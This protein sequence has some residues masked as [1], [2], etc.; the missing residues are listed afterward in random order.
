MIMDKHLI[1]ETCGGSIDSLGS[2]LVEWILTDNGADRLKVIHDNRSSPRG[3]EGCSFHSLA[4]HDHLIQDLPG[5]QFLDP[6]RRSA[7]LSGEAGDKTEIIA[8]ILKLACA[9]LESP[10]PS[11]RQAAALALARMGEEVLPVAGVLVTALEDG[12]EEVRFKAAF[13]LKVLGGSQYQPKADSVIVELAE[14]MEMID[15]LEPFVA[16]SPLNKGLISEGTGLT[17]EVIVD[18]TGKMFL[19]PEED[20]RGGGMGSVPLLGHRGRTGELVKVVGVFDRDIGI[21]VKSAI[22]L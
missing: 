3:R 15:S 11:V 16:D 20:Y 13:A 21:W 18:V 1:C 14:P 10:E 5:A 6:A 8:V 12:D 9:A 4:N 7:V 2:A 19:A 22:T 17:G